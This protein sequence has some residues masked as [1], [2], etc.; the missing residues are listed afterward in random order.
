MLD[1]LEI[2]PEERRVEFRTIISVSLNKFNKSR[3]F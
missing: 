1:P 3:N 2:E